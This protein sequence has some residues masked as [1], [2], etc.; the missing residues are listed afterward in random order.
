MPLKP[1]KS[2]LYT[3]KLELAG[4]IVLFC[5][6]KRVGG[7]GPFVPALKN[8]HTLLFKSDTMRKPIK[9]RKIDVIC[10]DGGGLLT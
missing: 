1:V 7:L 5:S 2:A 3:K 4:G 9:T 6:Q 8:R 10:S